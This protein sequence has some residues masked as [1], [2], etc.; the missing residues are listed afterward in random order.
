MASASRGATLSSRIFVE[1]ERS[2]I[3]PALVLC[4]KN[5]RR[6]AHDD[7]QAG[8]EVVRI[9]RNSWSVD[10]LFGKKSCFTADLA[11]VEWVN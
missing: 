7:S 3:S 2:L 8:G 9:I 10:K 1:P 5:T 11:T 4:G 6:E